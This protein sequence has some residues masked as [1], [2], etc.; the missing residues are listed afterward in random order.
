MSSDY[1]ISKKEFLE[2]FDNDVYG[3][4]WLN[5]IK[6]IK[7]SR[8]EKF[9]AEK[10]GDILESGRKIDKISKIIGLKINVFNEYLKNIKAAK[11]AE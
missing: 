6:Q 8:W 11:K 1:D 7:D 3:E 10:E 2:Q 4:N 5:K 9:I